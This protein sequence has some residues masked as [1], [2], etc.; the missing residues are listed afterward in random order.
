MA[1]F[2]WTPP[3][4]GARDEPSE[5]LFDL[6]A[7]LTTLFA[8]LTSMPVDVA[9]AAYF[10]SCKYIAERLLGLLLDP[11]LRAFTMDGLL[12]FMIDIETAEKCRELVF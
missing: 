2:D 7:Y 8:S 12:T 5:Y 11:A 6:V 10:S 9:R 4:G 1:E 3:P